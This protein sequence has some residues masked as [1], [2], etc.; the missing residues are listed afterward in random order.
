MLEVSAQVA[1]VNGQPT[2]VFEVDVVTA[3]RKNEVT[4]RTYPN[5]S[6]GDLKVRYNS[7]RTGSIRMTLVDM[8]GRSIRIVNFEASSTGEYIF[9]TAD[10]ELSGG[11]YVLQLRQGDYAGSVKVVR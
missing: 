4:L 8:K 10:L 1:E 3:L 5:P 11:V 2:V 7:G 6:E 9:P